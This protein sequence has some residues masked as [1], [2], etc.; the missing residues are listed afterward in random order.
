M[1]PSPT[2]SV[3]LRRDSDIPA[4][5]DA[6]RAVHAVS[7][8]PVGGGVHDP[9]KFLQTDD[10]AW[11]AVREKSGNESGGSEDSST[12]VV[13]H[14]ALSTPN[15]DDVSAALWWQLHPEAR[16]TPGGGILTLRRLFVHPSAQGAGLATRLIEAAVADVRCR[17]DSAPRRV[18]MFALAKDQGAIRLYRRLGW[19]HY[20]TAVHRWG[21]DERMDAECFAS[22]EV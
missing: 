20:G 12:A 13:G 16:S 22:P 7:G 9:P 10:K 18:V 5:S 11:V 6:L 8:Y 1:A 21:E 4:C 2:Y 3:R 15:E 19:E 17:E 14:A